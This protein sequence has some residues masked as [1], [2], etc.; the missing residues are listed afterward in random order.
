MLQ[1]G[2]ALGIA[3]FAAAMHLGAA[4]AYAACN[5]PYKTFEFAVPHVDIDECPSSMKT[6][7]A[8]CRASI[9]GD[10]IHVF[11]F[12]EAG[13]QCLMGVRSYEKDDYKISIK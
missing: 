13:E 6:Q 11:A 12:E 2:R 5:L 3:C 1:T 10:A 8:F 7:K 4:S 9:G